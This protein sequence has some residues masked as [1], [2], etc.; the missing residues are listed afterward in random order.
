MSPREALVEGRLIDA[1]ALQEAVVRDQPDDAAAG[2]FLFE[3]LTLAGRLHDARS[4]LF[5]IPTEDPDWPAARRG[6][7]HLLKAEYRRSHRL[8]KPLFLR[9]PPTHA[10]RRWRGIAAIRAGN[11]RAADWIDRGD[12]TS[13]HIIGHIDGREF[14]GLRDTD[15]RYASAFEAFVGPEYVWLPFEDVRRLTLFPPVGPLDVAFRPSRVRFADGGELS[16]VLPL[17]YPESHREGG[18]FAAGL[19]TDWRAD[20]GGVACGIGTRVLIL[21]EE[22]V[23]LGESRQLDLRVG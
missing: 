6:F 1:T 9:P 3:L 5:A 22:E 20:A 14:E 12:E 18:A 21:G 8:R 15:D 2:L 7:L 19:E 23:P 16:V 11:A 17:V 4:Q 13:P 10:R